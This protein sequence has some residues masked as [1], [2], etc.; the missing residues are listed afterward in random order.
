MQ[1]HHKILDL[2]RKGCPNFS[3]ADINGNTPLHHATRYHHLET[4][5]YLIRITKV[6][7][8]LANQQNLTP[9]DI[10]IQCQSLRIKNLLS[11]ATVLEKKNQ[12][13]RL[14]KA[15]QHGLQETV[16][17]SF[18]HPIINKTINALIFEGGGVKGIAYYGALKKLQQRGVIDI[19][20]IIYSA[21]TSAGAITALLLSAGYGIEEC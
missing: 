21:G 20:E 16:G 12:V 5:K 6:D 4:V 13:K 17:L 19:N 1:G 15:L 11:Q 18:P 7:K 14:K 8:H 9:L 10:S 2:L 3:V